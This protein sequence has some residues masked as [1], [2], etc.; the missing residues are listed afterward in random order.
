MSTLAHVAGVPRSPVAYGATCADAVDP[1][2]PTGSV[3]AR[4]GIATALR[5]T[6]I[7]FEERL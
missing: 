3:V 5:S 6:V 4:H 7:A 2:R 1:C